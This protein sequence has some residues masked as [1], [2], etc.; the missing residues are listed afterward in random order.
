[1]KS[2]FTFLLIYLAITNTFAQS[3]VISEDTPFNGR[4]DDIVFVDESEGWTV[5]GNGEIYHSTDAGTTWELQF[6]NTSEAYV[7]FRAI[8]F[9]NSNTGFAC[10]LDSVHYKTGD[11]GDTWTEFQLDI[12]GPTPGICG[13]SHVGD[14]VFGVGAYYNPAYFVHSSDAGE[15]WDYI[16][17]SPY[18][19]GLVACHFITENIGFV[20][21]IIESQGA[22]LLKTTDGGQTWTT[23]FQSDDGTS[24]V[25]KFWFVNEV[26]AYAVV[27]SWFGPGTKI[28]KSIDGGDTWELLLV[29]NDASLDLQG[30]GFEDE[31]HGWVG[32]RWS[33][34]QETFDGGQTWTESNGPD[35]INRFFM[36]SNGDLYASGHQVFKY[37]NTVG[38][39]EYSR[40]PDHLIEALRNPVDDNLQLKLTLTNETKVK[41]GLYSTNGRL[42]KTICEQRMQEGEHL[43]TV[44]MT[45]ISS[46]TYVVFLRSHESFQGMNIV[47]E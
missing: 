47:K 36:N 21:G 6:S 42:I 16:D 26:V 25:W 7:Y 44:D 24:Y 11:G 31:L 9:I 3:W 34:L 8:D 23:L 28:L 29:S 27:E 2:I 18:A 17:M 35:N 1:M 22:V 10:S 5:N 19:D 15:T 41:M 4:Y 20:G 13:L 43:L 37:D 12:P 32:P 33:P 39:N 45:D 40:S 30:I 38:L 14:H 46:G